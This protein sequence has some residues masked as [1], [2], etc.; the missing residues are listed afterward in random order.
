MSD[1]S[2]NERIQQLENEVKI[3]KEKSKEP[4]EP[5]E[6]KTQKALKEPKEKKERKPREKSAYNIYMSEFIAKEKARLGSDFNH[7][8]AFSN[9]AKK[10]R[11]S[12]ESN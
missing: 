12:K 10:W 7:K 6:P 4:K 1:L 9:C 3:L 11:E 2:I 8:E 5:K